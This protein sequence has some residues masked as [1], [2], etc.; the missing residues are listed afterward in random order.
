MGWDKLDR[1]D[2]DSFKAYVE[3]RFGAIDKSIVGID[4]KISENTPEL[5]DEIKLF[6]DKASEHLTATQKA[7]EESEAIR[8]LLDDGKEAITT[9]NEKLKAELQTT[10]SLNEQLKTNVGESQKSRA[11]LASS[12][13]AADQHVVDIAALL[14]N[15]K[16]L[17]KQAEDIPKRIEAA[18]KL[19]TQCEGFRDNLQGVVNLSLERKNQIDQAH[20]EIYGQDIAKLDDTAEHVDG[21]RDKIRK[22]FDKT[23]LDLKDLISRASTDVGS[24]T[25]QLKALLPGGMAAGLSAAYEAK[26]TDEINSLRSLEKNFVLAIGVLMLVSLIP[27][28]VDIWLL[29]QGK[30][31]LEVLG[32]TPVLQILPVYFPALWFAYSTNKKINL[33][34]RLIEEYTHKSVLGKTFSGLSNQI[35]SLPKE[36]AVAHELRTRLLYNVL[37]VS[38]ENPG[39]LITDYNKADHPVMEALENSSKLSDSIDALER[40]PGFKKLTQWLTDQKD[41]MADEVGK[42]VGAGLDAAKALVAPVK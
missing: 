1:G 26:A 5:V 13:A 17:A 23:D 22:S 27:F 6:R 8:Q 30:D 16:S 33:S 19:Q 20:I 7:A 32:L 9:S 42:K 10:L 39:K 37:Q 36:S 38:A 29:R 35:D 24:V 28:A 3:G 31:L 41:E 12:K 4:Q 2:F 34:K 15:T 14:E 25:D 21:L 11:D 40:I 18:D